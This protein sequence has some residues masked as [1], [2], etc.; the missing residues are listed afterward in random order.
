MKRRGNDTA[1]T[2]RALSWRRDT[3]HPRCVCV[4]AVD[5]GVSERFGVKAVDKGVRRETGRKA[6]NK[7]VR[8]KL[9]VDSLRL[10]AGAENPE[11]CAGMGKRSRWR[12]GDCMLPFFRPRSGGAR[13]ERT[14]G[15][16][17]APVSRVAA[18][19]P[20]V[21]KDTRTGGSC[22]VLLITG[23][24]LVRTG[25]EKSKPARFTNR[26][27]R[28]PVVLLCSDHLREVK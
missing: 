9:T 8:R 28:H 12:A 24:V 17:T 11:L 2:Q 6:T 15:S 5:K 3:P 22:Q 7:G 1:E 23:W 10:K 13:Q 25:V 16:D 18:R 27:M 26:N 14:Q 19:G 20:T 21:E 4:N